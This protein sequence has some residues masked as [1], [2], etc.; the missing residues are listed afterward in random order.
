MGRPYYIF[1]NGRL[2]RDE[3]T[4]LIEND[5]GEK[6]AI[7]VE[8]TECI[9]I[10]GEVDLNTKF[11][12]FISQHKIPVHIYNYYGFYSGSFLPRE[13]NLS[14]LVVIKQ[15]E[16]YLNPEQRLEIAK[17][18]VE[19]AMFHMIR[20][21]REHDGTKE[22]IEKIEKE[23]SNIPRCSDIS[24]LMGCEGRAKDEYYQAFN[25]FLCEPFSIEKREKHPPT[26]PLNALISF[27]NSL[28]YTSVLN[29]IYHTQLN[30]TVSYLHQP[31]ERRHSLSLDI[32]EIFKPL[33]GDPIIFKLINNRV[34]SLEDFDNSLNYCY[35]K[36]EGRKKFIKAFDEKMNTTIKHRK[37]K[38]NVSYKSII[39]YECYKLIKHL[40]G[41]E[42]Y[43]P[44]KAWW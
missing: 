44:F 12:N 6:K 21:L 31:S 15:A 11:F 42:K 19:G 10:F 20:N 7:P 27:S 30:S 36:E 32:S 40:L 13:Q 37:L 29:E 26:N 2:R 33:L 39:R 3:N 4:I 23:M 16:H 1:S 28:I 41:E 34:L 38:R 25:I 43:S 8:D 17:S 9:H 5:K 14:G 24:E 18:F 22:S 35:L